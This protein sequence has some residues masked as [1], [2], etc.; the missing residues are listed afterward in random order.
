MLCVLREKHLTYEL[1]N[2]SNHIKELRLRILGLNIKS[3]ATVKP[4]AFIS[5]S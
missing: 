2:E 1:D 3:K 4:V 5:L